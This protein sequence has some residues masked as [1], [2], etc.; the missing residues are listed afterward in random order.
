MATTLS[1]TLVLFILFAP[2]LPNRNHAAQARLAAI[3]R[4]VNIAIRSTERR[5]AQISHDAETLA[6]RIDSGAAAGRQVLSQ[7]I[8]P[9]LAVALSACRVES[10]GLSTQLKSLSLLSSRATIQLA[11][12][13][14]LGGVPGL[15]LGVR[16]SSGL[17]VVWGYVRRVW[18]RPTAAEVAAAEMRERYMQRVTEKCRMELQKPWDKMVVMVLVLR[19]NLALLT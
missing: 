5:L 4:D 18:R 7:N 2:H 19:E 8:Q 1:T 6:Q 16:V 12:A 14:R 15:G 10:A 3:R 9:S 13:R 11:E 17:A